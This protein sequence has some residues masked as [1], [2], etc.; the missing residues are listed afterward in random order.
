MLL[1]IL[2]CCFSGLAQETRPGGCPTISITGPSS[3]PRLNEI[4]A[5]TATVTGDTKGAKLEYQWSASAGEI[6]S[7]ERASEMKLRY[8][9]AGA[10]YTVVVEVKGL[11]AGCENIASDS[12][13]SLTNPQPILIA[14]TG[15]EIGGC[16]K[17]AVETS[18]IS[19]IDG[20]PMTFTAKV[21]G[22]GKRKLQYKWTLSNGEILE[23][24]GTPEIKVET[25]GYQGEEIKATLTI[26]GLSTRCKN[27]ASATGFVKPK[28]YLDKTN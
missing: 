16:P 19:V 4:G 1:L 8:S 7:G 20:Y 14:E 24:Q 12:S 25:L 21:N 5:Y 6:V 13:C 15:S 22:A 17:V 2:V 11:P 27:K 28:P 26:R 9:L 3:V 18:F 10:S 23:G